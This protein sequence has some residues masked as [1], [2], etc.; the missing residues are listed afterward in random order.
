LETNGE[1]WSDAAW[2][3]SS[4]SHANGCVE[5]AFGADRVAVRDSKHQ[6]G[7]VLIFRSD[8]W[9]AFLAGVRGGEFELPN[10]PTS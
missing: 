2:F 9:R 6:H 10:S 7:P 1:T 4:F 8:E 3:K 5:V